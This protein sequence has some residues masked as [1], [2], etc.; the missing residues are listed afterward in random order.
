MIGKT[1]WEGKLKNRAVFAIALAMALAGAFASSAL[2]AETHVFQAAVGSGELSTAGGLAVDGSSGNLYVA[3]PPAGTVLRFGPSGAAAEFAAT[4]TNS[5][6]GFSFDAA[7]TQVAVDNSAGTNAGD[8]YVTNSFGGG[9]QAFDESGE[10]AP[11]TAV[12]SYISGNTLEGAPSGA[13]GE[14]CGVAVDGSGAIYVGDFGGNVDIYA[15]SGEFLT[16]LA[17]PAPCSVAVDSAGNVYANPFGGGVEAFVPSAFPVTA[18][19]TYGEAIVVTEVTT[20]AVAIDAADDNLYADQVNHVSQFASLAEGSSPI[21]EFGGGELSE[22]S[23]GIAV[24]RS[25]GERDGDVYA[26]QSTQVDRFGPLVTVPDPVTEAASDVV[27]AGTATLHGSVNPV[28][29]ELSQCEFEYGR[30]ETYGSTVPCAESAAEI[31]AGEAP[32]PVHADVSGLEAGVYHF[33]LSVANA[34]GPGRGADLTL[35]VPGAPAVLAQ[36]AGFTTTEANLRAT[37]DPSNDV[38]TY[39]FEYGPT[40]AYGSVTGTH[41]I[42]AGGSPVAVSVHLTGLVPAT[43]YH[44]HVIAANSVT[45]ASGEDQTFTTRA[46]APP[47]TCANAATRA[48]QSASLL[49]DCR[50][51]ELVS[52]SEKNGADV[53]RNDSVQAAFGGGGAVFS[54]PG[55]FADSPSASALS[56]YRAVREGE[57][58]TTRGIS[59]PVAPQ[60]GKILG[61]SLMAVSADLSRMV[62]RAYPDP[63]AAPG[64]QPLAYDF[65]R[66]LLP[67]GP[68]ENL[69]PVAP[70]ASSFEGEASFAGADQA[71]DTIGIDSAQSLLPEAPFGSQAY[72]WQGG[73]LHYVGVLPDESQATESFIGG[74]I[75]REKRNAI[76]ADGSQIAFTA[77]SFEVTRG[78]YLRENLSET[79]W[80]SK[81]QRVPPDPSP[82]PVTYQGASVSG[83]RVFFLSAEQLLNSDTDA[84]RDLYVFEPGSE[85]LRQISIDD[86]PA[87]GEESL[88][89]QVLGMS[90]DGSRLYFAAF[91]ELI[92]GQ[93]AAPGLMHIYAWQDSGGPN[94]TLSY[95]TSL[96]P[97]LDAE[98]WS[99][100]IKFKNR[101]VQVSPSGQYLLYTARTPLGNLNAEHTEVYRYDIEAGKS[102]CVSCDPGNEESRSDASL[103]GLPSPALSG[104]DR[105]GFSPTNVTDSG[106]VFFETA[107]P[108]ALGDANGLEDVYEW[109]NGAVGLI[110]SGLGA[111]EAH[112]G[113]ASGDGGDVFFLSGER[114]VGADHDENV[115]LYDA[116]VNGGIAAQNATPPVPCEGEACGSGSEPPPPLP[117]TGSHKKRHG[118]QKRRHRH[119]R[120]HHHRRHAHR[121]HHGHAQRQGAEHG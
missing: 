72:V 15:P 41:T 27:A 60:G 11:F 49:P 42:P 93:P 1:G 71:L 25:G 103:F 14:V 98:V 46:L 79:I 87:D 83:D 59:P 17:A 53:N 43:E 121:H 10:P 81:S 64:E 16:S 118:N 24:D 52:P 108:L 69:T 48:L 4:G 18:S 107:D 45:E 82:Q 38:T 73:E 32:V 120:R 95:V 8:F 89:T 35:A 75:G 9:I 29:I 74:R 112:F 54:S 7:A 92:P 100:Q 34:N 109:E 88:T 26:A 116:R 86:E 110:S 96:S 13:F 31:G 37:I 51:Y 90:E 12:A 70:E 66:R 28:G 47:D 99:E 62:M 77:S 119:H 19:T 102:I 20:A 91:G 97:G 44:F 58:W 105:N 80:A 30:E 111:T 68:F 85:T 23:R 106:R 76:S 101:L 117:S 21:A 40:A 2:A 50:A 33:R 61:T 78:L 55:A 6:S 94:G 22:E 67:D 114:L 84:E 3:D 36:S 56:Y 104:I 39:R 115:D 65:Y 63:P 5:I 57:G 113:D